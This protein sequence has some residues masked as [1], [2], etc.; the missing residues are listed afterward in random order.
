MT[1]AL[2][3]ERSDD[4]E[5]L[6][7]RAV[8]SRGDCKAHAAL[9]LTRSC[10]HPEA[11]AWW[12]LWL[13]SATPEVALQLVPELPRGLVLPLAS[14]PGAVDAMTGGDLHGARPWA[15]VRSAVLR[16]LDPDDPGSCDLATLVACTPGTHPD[17][18]A[19][20]LALL[21]AA[22]HPSRRALVRAAEAAVDRA[23]RGAAPRT[24]ATGRPD[25]EA[26][27]AAATIL[28]ALAPATEEQERQVA[29]RC[30]ELVER[31]C[32]E[33]PSGR[34]EPPW[35]R[36]GHWVGAVLACLRS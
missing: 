27:L 17:V 25:T 31:C 9:E 28:C 26:V 12:W 36:H 4:Y 22:G 15:E 32:D 24:P 13:A 20:A 18:L 8:H 33:D 19:A 23:T 21:E 35:H 2:D 1:A 16:R 11:F 5:A 10:A 3:L 6:A 7:A 30:A 14:V 34:V 29:A